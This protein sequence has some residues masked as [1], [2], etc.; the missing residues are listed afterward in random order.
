MLPSFFTTTG[1]RNSLLRP[2]P[3]RLLL[4][5]I[6]YQRS[7][8]SSVCA[9]GAHLGKLFET[10]GLFLPEHAGGSLAARRVAVPPVDG[11]T[12][13][14]FASLNSM[15]PPAGTRVNATNASS[16]A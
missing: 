8:C 15:L 5:T 6:Q 14:S 10:P 4:K 3:S 2:V 16:G 9:T 11:T 13:T 12:S 1:E 7:P